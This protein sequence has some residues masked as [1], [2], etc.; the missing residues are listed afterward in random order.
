[1]KRNIA[2][3]LAVLLCCVSCAFRGCGQGFGDMVPT[4]A[5][6]V[7]EVSCKLVLGLAAAALLLRRGAP[8]ETVCAGAIVG[9]TVGLGLGLPVLWAMIRKREA[10]DRL[11][12]N[13]CDEPDGYGRIL[14]EL[15][16]TSVP[17]TLGASALNL[18]ALVDTRLICQQLQQGMGV[19][20]ETAK[21]LYGVYAKA[22]TLFT[23]PSSLFA[24]PITLSVVPAIAGA[25]A[26]RDGRGARELMESA[27]RV[28]NLLAMPAAMGMSMASTAVYCTLY[29]SGSENGPVLLAILG[30]SSYFVCL[31]QA[32]AA[33][34]QACGYEKTSLW[35]VP[36]GGAVKVAACR[37]LVGRVGIVGA[38]VGMLACYAVIS[39]LNLG[40]ILLRLRQRPRL[41]RVT[42]RPLLCAVTMGAC[43]W[44]VQ[45]LMLRHFPA[46]ASSRAGMGAILAVTA[47]LSAVVYV[48]CAVR[49]GAVTVPDA[50]FLPQTVRRKLPGLRDPE[51]S[52]EKQG[53]KCKKRLATQEEV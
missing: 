6:T 29:G 8:Q 10:S 53:K 32:T 23:L 13:T 24:S 46:L 45:G 7:L 17:I 22:Q 31:H 18:F 51:K 25:L 11:F 27:L 26:R 21:S 9:V 34:L 28:T 50:Q 41:L 2:F 4:S 16:K 19:S 14:A 15:L 12:F 40:V 38:P 5:A 39:A 20:Y 1:M 33:I 30:A 3:L 49:F 36:A 37:F 52:A 47:A 43:T 44:S 35:T 42:L 48:A